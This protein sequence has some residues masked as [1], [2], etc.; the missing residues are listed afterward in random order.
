MPELPDVEVLKTLAD[1]T[2]RG[3]GIQRVELS[4]PRLLETPPAATFKHHIEGSHVR[5]TRRHGKYL[6]AVLGRGAL[7]F[8]FGMTGTLQWGKGADVPEHTRMILWCHENDRLAYVCQRKLGRFGWT[9]DIGKLLAE[10]DLGPDALALDVNAFRERLQARH[11]SIK[12][13]LM[14]Q[15]TLA[16]IG[17]I[18]SDEI[19]FHAKIAPQSDARALGEKHWRALYTATQHVLHTAVDK[20]ARPNAMPHSWLLPRRQAGATCPKCGGTVEHGHAG[21]RSTYWCP[22]CQVALRA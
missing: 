20:G 9:A 10:K 21:Q 4:E 6:F 7:Y 12:S 14:N 15:S 16:G 1:R 3:R 5:A 17:N 13:A 11:G 8:H 19:L 22:N 2:I 18:Y